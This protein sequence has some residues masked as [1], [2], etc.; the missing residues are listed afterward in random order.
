ML[1]HHTDRSEVTELAGQCQGIEGQSAVPWIA[2]GAVGVLVLV[3]AQAGHYAV[4]RE[5]P[6]RHLAHGAIVDDQLVLLAIHGRELR[7]RGLRGS[8]GTFSAHAG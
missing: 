8:A 4:G 2:K 5:Y 6:R 7:H 1:H 3:P